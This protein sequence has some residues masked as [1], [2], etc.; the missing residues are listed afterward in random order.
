MEKKNKTKET[1]IPEEDL[2]RRRAI[3]ADALYDVSFNT[4]EKSRSVNILEFLKLVINENPYVSES[5]GTRV[6]SVDKND[7]ESEFERSGVH[8]KNYNIIGI[9][10]DKLYNYIKSGKGI[11]ELLVILGH[12]V[13]HEYQSRYERGIKNE[14][15]KDIDIDAIS[16]FVHDQNEEYLSSGSVYALFEMLGNKLGDNYEKFK[17]LPQENKMSLCKKIAL[18]HYVSMASERQAQ[19]HGYQFSE[20]ILSCFIED[21]MV[22]KSLK[23]WLKEELKNIQEKKKFDKLVNAHSD[24]DLLKMSETI[25]TIPVAEICEM[26][27]HLR[28]ISLSVDIEGNEKTESALKEIYKINEAVSA[29]LT[30]KMSEGIGKED[31]EYLI[32]SFAF[33]GLS[34]E[35]K[36]FYE[37]YKGRSDVSKK[38]IKIIDENI[39]DT[40]IE[41]DLP[42]EA[43]SQSLEFMDDKYFFEIVNALLDNKKI[44]AAVE[45]FQKRSIYNII[46]PCEEMQTLNDRIIK[47]IDAVIESVKNGEKLSRAEFM[48]LTNALIYFRGE[49]YQKTHEEMMHYAFR[50]GADFMTDEEEIEFI[51]NKYG[52]NIA[53]FVNEE[54]NERKR[55]DEQF[56]RRFEEARRRGEY[57]RYKQRMNNP[58]PAL[59]EPNSR[60]QEE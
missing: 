46:K 58:Y 45:M 50:D 11:A 16:K 51:R 35:T 38:E 32:Y 20:H 59:S 19:E 25:K 7:S 41:G 12:E 3:L 4:T 52:D 54:N 17:Q 42:L 26:I 22:D 24:E 39:K 8:F 37:S 14:R 56:H 55:R 23:P 30:S 49:E 34:S 36:R 53:E 2:L 43:Y 60:E 6:V 21:D 48:S 15:F 5:P 1:I 57:N 9:A 33:D 29:F 18:S 13:S 44:I 40:F 31:I 27:K 47:E 10:T 28:K